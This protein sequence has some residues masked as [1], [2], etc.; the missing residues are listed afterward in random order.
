MASAVIRFEIVLPCPNV[1][2]LG[3]GNTD[4]IHTF[5]NAMVAI[6][7]CWFYQVSVAPDGDGNCWYALFGYLTNAQTAAALS[8]LNALNSALQAPWTPVK[9]VKWSATTEP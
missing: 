8:A 1:D 6:A 3:Q 5:I 7:T 2:N 4:A 9:C